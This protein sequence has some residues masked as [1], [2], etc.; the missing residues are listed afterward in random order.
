MSVYSL[1][2]PLAVIVVLL[3]FLIY[4]AIYLFM[5]SIT[6]DG[7]QNGPETSKLSE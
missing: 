3:I 6:D 4:K 2:D 1:F 7:S 5:L